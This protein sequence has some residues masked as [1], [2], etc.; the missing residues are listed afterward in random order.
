MKEQF[1]NEKWWRVLLH[2]DDIHTFECAG[3]H[4]RGQR[5]RYT[6]HKT[7]TIDIATTYYSDINNYSY[8]IIMCALLSGLSVLACV[9]GLFEPFPFVGFHHA[10]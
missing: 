6:T 3:A 1:D 9:A 7:L 8:H 10:G 2:N 4:G 5:L